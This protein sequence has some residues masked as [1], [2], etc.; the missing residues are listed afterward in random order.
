MD[1]ARKMIKKLFK[2]HR[3]RIKIGHNL[4]LKCVKSLEIDPV[5]QR[6]YASVKWRKVR[7]R[8]E[9]VQKLVA[10]KAVNMSSVQKKKAVTPTHQTAQ[11]YV[12]VRQR[13]RALD[14]T[15]SRERRKAT[16]DAGR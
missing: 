5:L 2:T 1:K 15:D 14:G 9:Q 11:P 10:P 13:N 12:R 4:D 8:I 6:F 3:K 16:E 7:G